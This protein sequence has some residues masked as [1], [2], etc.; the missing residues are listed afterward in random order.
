MTRQQRTRT[1]RPN[2]IPLE[3]PKAVT[4]EEARHW[5]IA[6]GLRTQVVDCPVCDGENQVTIVG[7]D[8]NLGD[9]FRP[10]LTTWCRP[11]WRTGVQR[12][13]DVYLHRQGL[14]IDCTRCN[15]KGAVYYHGNAPT[16]TT[17]RGRGVRRADWV[18]QSEPDLHLSR[19]YEVREYATYWLND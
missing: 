15:G 14:V 6:R 4:P 7:G 13:A 16:C 9:T 19:G 10:S 1:D 3:T 12:E 8:P 5:A 2:P 18:E 11:C 17:C